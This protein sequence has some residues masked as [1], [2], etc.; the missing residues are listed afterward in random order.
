MIDDGQIQQVTHYFGF[1][2]FAPQVF[3][4]WV[5]WLTDTHPEDVDA[6]YDF[7]GAAPFVHS[8]AEALALQD[9]YTNEFVE[10][11]ANSGTD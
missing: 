3:D 2:L 5:A 4:V 9:Q 1:N 8:T 10:L 6:M 11:Q 7:T